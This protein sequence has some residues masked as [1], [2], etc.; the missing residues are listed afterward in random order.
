MITLEIGKAICSVCP[1]LKHG[2]S[3]VNGKLTTLG[4]FL[5]KIKIERK[6]KFVFSFKEILTL[7]HLKIIR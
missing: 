5:L 3:S 1:K 4:L 2:V 6:R 7:K